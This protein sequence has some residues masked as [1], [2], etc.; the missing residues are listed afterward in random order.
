MKRAK[1]LLRGPAV[2]R[3]LGTLLAGY[4]RLVNRTNRLVSDPA[5]PAAFMAPLAPAIIAMWHGQ[6]FMVPFA[7]PASLPACVMISK[8]RDAEVNAVAAE[9]LGLRTIRASGAHHAP[10]MLRKGGPAG[11]REMLRALEEGTSTALTADVPKVSRVAGKGIVLLA[12]HSGRPIV[13]VAF[14]TSRRI[15]VDSWDHASVNLPFGRAGMAAGQPIW[16][17]ADADD[18]A[19]E[20]FRQVVTEGLDRAT[21][22]AYE[23]AGSA[24]AYRR[25]SAHG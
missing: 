17:P 25:G 21:D 4:L 14:A 12:K 24:P 20:R 6:H 16:V 18:A 2:P 19:V 22:R 15:D 13:P 5:D 23:L 9:R 10:D 11:F 8:S 3:A 7:R 1:R